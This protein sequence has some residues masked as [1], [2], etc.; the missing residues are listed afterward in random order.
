MATDT[1][2]DLHTDLPLGQYFERV[3][4]T[5]PEYSAGVHPQPLVAIR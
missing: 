1:H 4:A 3:V 2:A 5:Q